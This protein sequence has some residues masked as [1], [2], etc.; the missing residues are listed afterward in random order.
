VATGVALVAFTLLLSETQATM[1]G[2]W[3]ALLR[4]P[5]HLSLGATL[6][7]TL[8]LAVPLLAGAAAGFLAWQCARL[9]QL[10]T[11]LDAVRRDADR[12]L[13]GA[14]LSHLGYVASGVPFAASGLPGLE[15][16]RLATLLGRGRGVLLLGDDGSGKST[17]LAA[18]AH[19]LSGR[20]RLLPIAFG[21][22][23]LP[24]PVSLEWF[25]RVSGGSDDALA[26]C[27]AELLWRHG[28]RH[29]AARALRALHHWN[30]V[31]LCDGLDEVPSPQRPQ[32]ATHLAA[33]LSA[34]YPEA[35]LVVTSALGTYLNDVPRLAG[36]Q[37]LERVVVTG[38]RAGDA[39]H[40]LRHAAHSPRA[41]SL[42]AQYADQTT[43]ARGLGGQLTHPATLAALTAVLD[44][45][46][47]PPPGR[48]HLLR[49]YA[50]VLC[51]SAGDDTL[52]DDMG[53][54][55]ESL[56]GSLRANN[57]TAIPL[58][59][60]DEVVATVRQWLERT[61]GPQASERHD[62]KA[63]IEVAQQCGILE[64]PR[65]AACIR[66]T[67]HCV[68]AVFAALALERFARRAPDQPLPADLLAPHW[69][70]PL[71]L[72]AGFDSE[73]GRLA[74]RLLE[75]PAC[76][77]PWAILA[78]ALALAAA[79]EAFAPA[80]TELH[81]SDAATPAKAERTL[82]VVLDEVARR[83]LGADAR[84]EFIQELSTI[85]RHG[86][87]DLTTHLVIVARCAG[88]GR[89]VRAQAIELLG[90]IAT[91]V[92]LDGLFE[93][94]PETD[95]VLRDAVDRAF[96]AAGPLAVPRLQR[97]L[98]S[99]D[100][101][102][103]LR[104]L[105]ALGQHREGGI[106]AIAAA[107][108]S[109]DARERETAARALGALRAT[110]AVPALAALLADSTEAVRLASIEALGQMRTTDATSALLAHASAPQASERTSTAA[111]LGE[112]H[113]AGALAVLLSMLGD[114]AASV[115]AAAA[116]ALGKLGKMDDERVMRSLRERLG[117]TDPWAQASAATA[118]R[119]LGQ[120]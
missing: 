24:I 50:D 11:Y 117:D 119:R 73:P 116:E 46:P 9:L 31:L 29:L 42:A 41:R 16:V 77:G 96:V 86:L 21:R 81:V 106:A 4:E 76:T 2:V 22:L 35:R 75:L 111:A 28:A 47:A 45:E 37:S 105:A 38:V 94:L 61:A 18:Y 113:D 14:A 5:G 57:L 12:R 1:P 91:P 104:A 88:L 95:A 27:A 92:S 10:A 8:A 90:G 26:S 34:A 110:E 13:R 98:G 6:A 87:V 56:A 53:R 63:L 40:L 78:P 100:E 52:V 3:A 68:E 97:A 17:A 89:I 65:G 99:E 72:W 84:K 93:L 83:T 82:R 79:L 64:Q 20:R 71:L 74:Q 70:E 7:L 48:G 66:F 80:L 55:L 60:G 107:T 15:E 109:G 51:A 33:A 54:V 108:T 19:A 102:L 23:P 112:T 30:V 58:T 59:P 49:A 44:T 43:M 36:L 85:E 103:R 101:R 39:P 32:V 25:A 62:L 69:F 115:R 120:R 114:D 67:S 118:L